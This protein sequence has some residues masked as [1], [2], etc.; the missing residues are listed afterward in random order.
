MDLP[1]GSD[2]LDSLPH[3]PPMR[4][5]EEVLEVQPGRE[6]RARRRTS[7]RDWYFQGHFPGNPVV[8]AVVLIELIAQTGG[9]AAYWG[10]SDWSRPSGGKAV[11]VA[12]FSNFKFPAA[13]GPEVVLEVKVRIVGH[14]GKL[15]RVEGEVR[16]ED[17]L[18]ARGDVTLAE[19][20]R[21]GTLDEG[22]A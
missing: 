20:E 6:A 9:I 12:A 4:L 11:R 3:R 8:P 21:G 13:V 1:E 10:P 19:I 7:A 16:T 15:V 5:I 18:V 22:G 17:V 2:I 14:F